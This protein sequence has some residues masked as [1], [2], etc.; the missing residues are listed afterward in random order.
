MCCMQLFVLDAL[1]F[2]TAM[3]AASFLQRFT[4]AG[5]CAPTHIMV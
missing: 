3:E 2:N 4:Q 5:G 1:T